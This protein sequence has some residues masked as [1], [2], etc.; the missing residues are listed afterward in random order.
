M[1]ADILLIPYGLGQKV[2]FEK[3]E[4]PK[5][6][7]LALENLGALSVERANEVLRPVSD[8]IRKVRAGLPE[9]CSLIG[10]AGSPWT[11]AT[12]MIEGG[13]SKDRI[14][15]RTL[16]WSQPDAFDALLDLLA[17]ASAQYLKAQADAG[18]NALK[19]F[20]SWAE[21]LPDPLFDRVIIRPT[22]RIIDRLRQMGVTLPVIG[23]PR[24]AGPQAVRYA[25]ETGIQCLALDHGLD[26]DWARGAFPKDLPL[27]GQLDPAVLRA[28][29]TCWIPR[30]TGS[31]PPGRA[32]PM[33][34]I[35]DMAFISTRPLKTS[36]A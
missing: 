22:K 9:T 12:Y 2:W 36:R 20:D 16:A 11:V 28:G 19:L 23:F 26:T 30:S 35:S 5:L 3:G 4:G 13:G 15:A 18:A 8:T 1:F 7:P 6:E 24:G 32:G 34:S 10:F 25:K 31:F 17:E 14:N 27:Q 21:G 33:S 29:A